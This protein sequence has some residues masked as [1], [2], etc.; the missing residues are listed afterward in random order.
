MIN[1]IELDVPSQKAWEENTRNEEILILERNTNYDEKEAERDS[2][3]IAL[4]RTDKNNYYIFTRTI[5]NNQKYDILRASFIFLDNSTYNFKKQNIEEEISKNEI[6]KRI[7]KVIYYISR[8]GRED[9]E[10]YNSSPNEKV[11]KKF[12]KYID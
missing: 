1:N 2:K 7:R 6:E 3:Y 9:Y 12:E 11:V 4:V 8:H 10:Y 5:V